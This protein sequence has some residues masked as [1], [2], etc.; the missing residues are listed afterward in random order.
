MLENKKIAYKVSVISIIVN[1]LL[2]LF[3]FIAGILAHSSAMISDSIHSMSDVAS[4]IIVIIGVKLS[5][6][7]ADK[8]HPYGHERIECLASLI[9]AVILFITGVSVGYQ[10]ILTVIEKKH[11][12][13]VIPGILSLIAAITSIIIKEWMY[14]YTRY[15]AKKIDSNVL[16]ADAWHHRSDALS[17]IGSF[18]GIF[19]SRLG[20][21]IFDSLAGIVIC[22]FILKVAVDIF[23]DAMDK[24]VDRSCDI[25]T[26]EQIKQII[27]ENEEVLEIDS[28]M[29]RLFG[30]K[31]YVDIEIQVDGDKTLIEAHQVAQQVHDKVEEQFLFIK[32]CMVHVNPSK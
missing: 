16:M 31:A 14:W 13:I 5:S 22:I 20:F 27:L 17:S 3:K 18:I 11:D 15:Y 23:K 32:H 1:I 2:F 6:K 12:V 28:I 24:L 21:P 10:G 8:E 26:V 25:D 19:V 4:T 30:N 7:E 9:L 29:T